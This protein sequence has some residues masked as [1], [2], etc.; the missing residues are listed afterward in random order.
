MFSKESSRPLKIP[1]ISYRV[2][3]AMIEYLI[4]GTTEISPEIATELL[5]AA[6][7]YFLDDLKEICQH[8]LIPSIN[9]DNIDILITFAHRYSAL[10]LKK[11]CIEF[12]I[13]NDVGF[14]RLRKLDRSVLDEI[15]SEVSFRLRRCPR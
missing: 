10:V 8:I 14:D 6:D 7:E 2:F 4:S 5:I 12:L 11:F 15:L 3:L 13:T 9:S 1:E